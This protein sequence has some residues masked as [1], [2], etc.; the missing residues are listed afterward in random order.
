MGSKIE[1]LS[2]SVHAAIAF[3]YGAVVGSFLNVC[4]WRMPREESLWHP[5]SHCPSC[6]TRLRLPDLVPLLS[7]LWQRGRC[8][9]CD[10]RISPRYFAVELITALLFA[11]IGWS[12]GITLDSALLALWV[13]L[14]VATLFI[15]L[16]HFI[17]PDELNIAGVLIG[18]VRDVVKLN[19]LDHRL[20]WGLASLPLP[21]GTVLHLPRSVAGALL[22][23]GALYLVRSL[24]TIA[25]HKEAMGLGDV[26]LAA[27]MGAN[28]VAGQLIIAGF[29]AV[30]VGSV[31]GVFL[32]A[33]GRLGGASGGLEPGALDPSG[34]EHPES[35]VVLTAE[36]EAGSGGVLL[37][38]AAPPAHQAGEA[39]VAAPDGAG[40]PLELEAVR[41]S[42]TRC[43]SPGE[44]DYDVPAGA[45]PFGPFLVVGVLVAIF[46]GE[47][48]FR[49]YL[50][51]MGLGE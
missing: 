48:L 40:E 38:D 9:Y 28:L 7:F 34:R 41:D 6:D 17:I 5:P 13:G 12:F 32:I 39:S 47:P 45:L 1:F 37:P 43:G 4:I 46:W 22:F 35:D 8:R 2:P 18:V 16:E 25:F 10:A 11:G 44:E 3:I 33:T 15:D 49:A 27:A 31:I 29:T 20:T 21:G 42:H 26:K 36:G 50:R 14:L 23:M 24:G 51:Y 30:L 19:S